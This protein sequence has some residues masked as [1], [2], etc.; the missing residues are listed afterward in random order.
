[1]TTENQ[2]TNTYKHP[3]NGWTSKTNYSNING[4]DW[5]ISTLKTYSGLLVCTAQA[6]KFSKKKGAAESIFMMGQDPSITLAKEKSRATEKTVH[7][8]HLKGL[9]AFDLLKDE[10]KLPVSEQVDDTQIEIGQILVNQDREHKRAVFKKEE[11]S[12][13]TSYHCVNLKTHA[14]TREDFVTNFTAKFGIGTYYLEG[15]SIG[16]DELTELVIMAHKLRAECQRQKDSDKLLAEQLRQGKIDAGLPKVKI[17]SNAKAIIIATRMVDKSDYQSDYYHVCSDKTVYLAF[18]SSEKNN[19]KEM[20][21]V[22]ENFEHT[23]HYGLGKGCFQ[24]FVVFDTTYSS[25]GSYKSSGDRSPYHNELTK[26]DKSHDLEFET[27]ELA[28]EHIAKQKP[29]TIIND[30]GTEVHFRWKIGETEFEHRERGY[31]LAKSHNS[32]WHVSKINFNYNQPDKFKEDLAIAIEED[33]YFV[34]AESTI[35]QPKTSLKT[36]N[37]NIGSLNLEIIDYSEKAIALAG[38]TQPIKAQL[39]KI[40]GRYNAHLTHP[41]TKDK[42]KGWVFSKKQKEALNSLINSL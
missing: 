14:I 11:K 24:P 17:P 31:S 16:E 6:C 36:P 15:E 10:D 25:N 7:A 1:M 22:S 35:Q 41:K 18:S 23:S 38:D 39:H 40:N 33:R 12:F 5:K 26:D 4:Y 37:E 27:L 21:K 30:S 2:E 28:Q 32:G 13:D 3:S 34:Q 20:R 9:A 42:F 19:F 8:L 29:L